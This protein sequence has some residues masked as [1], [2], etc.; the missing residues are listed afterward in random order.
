MNEKEK[1]D[2]D[3]AVEDLFEREINKHP[4]RWPIINKIM[5]DFYHRHFILKEPF[6]F[7]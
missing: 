7:E 6:D 3:R 4:E 1:R 5:E 2:C